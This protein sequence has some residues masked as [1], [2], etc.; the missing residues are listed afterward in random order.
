[1]LESQQFAREP[2]AN[3]DEVQS[4]PPL[5]PHE[6]PLELGGINIRRDEAGYYCLNDLH[7]AAGGEKKHGPTYF[8]DRQDTDD[9]RQ[10]LM[11][12]RSNT[13]IPVIST[14]NTVRGAAGGT[15]VMKELV[16]AYAMWI[17]AAFYLKVIRA[18]DQLA[19]KGIAVHE[20][21]VEKFANDPMKM[22]GI[23]G[24]QMQKLMAE[25]DAAQATIL[26][27]KEVPSEPAG[28]NPA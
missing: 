8:L 26:K 2:L 18:Y 16:Y 12:E 15:Y 28:M 7:K 23:I 1:M 5:T 17:N 27:L 11:A 14:V 22:L 9:L 13:G 10:A 24:E 19:T 25:R 3:C 20:D 6:Q 4:T 21:H